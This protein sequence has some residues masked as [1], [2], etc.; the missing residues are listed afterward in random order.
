MAPARNRQWYHGRFQFQ[1]I[2]LCALRSFHWPFTQIF[3][4]FGTSTLWLEHPHFATQNQHDENQNGTPNHALRQES[5]DVRYLRPEPFV[6]PAK[7][8]W[9]ESQ[10]L[11]VLT[12]QVPK[13]ETWK[14]RCHQT[15][16]NTGLT[17]LS[18]SRPGD[19]FSLPARE[20]CFSKQMARCDEQDSYPL[21]SFQMAR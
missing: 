20:T 3:F 15:K 7:N 8:K 21:P 11:A 4:R 2:P 14:C 16:K 19:L 13:F 5:A 18:S 10:R 6:F 17:R 1:I 12:L 9:H